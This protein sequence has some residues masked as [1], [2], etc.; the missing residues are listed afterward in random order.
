MRSGPEIKA[1]AVARVYAGESRRAVAEDCGVSDS[2][3][4]EWL[5]LAESRETAQGKELARSAEEISR[6]ITEKERGTRELLL[7]RLAAV[8]PE[9]VSVRE[10][11]TAYGI[12]TD[13]SMLAKGQPTSIVGRS[14]MDSEIRNLLEQMKENDAK[15]AADGDSD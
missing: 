11:A 14:D 8:V 2:T 7:D 3:V 15:V 4:R 9:S 1:Q 10:I 12:L 6:A 13:K 5:K